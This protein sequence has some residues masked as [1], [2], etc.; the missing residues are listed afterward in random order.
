MRRSLDRLGCAVCIATFAAIFGI[1]LCQ[2]AFRYVLN[3]LLVWTEELARYLYIWVCYL[4]AAAAFRRGN[5]IVVA[6][7]F[8]RLPSRLAGTVALGPQALAV[9]FF[10]SLAVL[11]VRLMARAHTILAITLPIPWSAIYAAPPVAAGLML[12][13]TLEPMGGTLAQVRGDRA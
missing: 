12:L 6:L 8:E 7:V 10:V 9:V 3:A 1:M 11:G 4:G 13:Q 2:I 5:H